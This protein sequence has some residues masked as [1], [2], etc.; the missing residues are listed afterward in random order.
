MSASRLVVWRHG[1]T[2]W[3]VEGR[4]QGQI[5]VP[6]DRTGW[7]QAKAAA[8]RLALLDPV[9]IVSSDLSRAAQT[10]VALSERTGLPVTHDPRLREI[11]TG[12]M[13]GFTRAEFR[14]RFPGVGVGHGPDA[15]HGGDGETERAVAERMVAALTDIAVA[16]PD[17][18]TIVVA[19][20]G[21]AARVGVAA[22]AGLPPEGWRA[23]SGIANCSWGVI[24]RVAPLPEPHPRGSA[25]DEPAPGSVWRIVEWNAGS[26]P[27]PD[28]APEDQPPG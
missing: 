10:A 26:L 7:Q 3:N 23:L 25:G 24:G 5:D 2:E 16:A 12:S 9:A 21:V 4:H 8:Q 19:T 1:Q 17:G 22:L 11:D 27:E 14:E 18:S 28:E 20:H 6:L 13:G 15:P